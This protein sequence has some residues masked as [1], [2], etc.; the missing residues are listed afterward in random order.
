MTDRQVD[1]L[2]LRYELRAFEDKDAC[3]TAA[4]IVALAGEPPA[5]VS[6]SAIAMRWAQIYP[7]HATLTGRRN[8]RSRIKDGLNKLAVA[9]VVRRGD[10]LVYVI[11]A[12]RLAMSAGN[13]RI[14]VDDDGA[15]IPPA[16]WVRRPAAPLHLHHVQ[17][18]LETHRQ[19]T[20]AAGAPDV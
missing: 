13:L 10:G 3:R 6:R 19:A 20:I 17:Q 9:G 16:Q 11:D 8:I 4:L 1:E 18:P 5:P 7:R 15:A 2:N 14:L 12:G